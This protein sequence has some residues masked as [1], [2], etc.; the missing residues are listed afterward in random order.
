M[1]TFNLWIAIDEVQVWL[2]IHVALCF[3]RWTWLF[4]Q[5]YQIAFWTWHSWIWCLTSKVSAQRTLPCGSRLTFHCSSQGLVQTPCRSS[6]QTSAVTP[7]ERCELLLNLK[8]QICSLPASICNW[9]TS[10][11][12]W[13]QSERT[14]SCVQ[15]PLCNPVQHCLQLHT[16]LPRV[17]VQPRYV[18]VFASVFAMCL[19]DEE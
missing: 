18:C 1:D 7:T 3:C 8:A 17:P 13:L 11:F 15:R 2:L 12:L 14:W 4:L 19:S 16:R 10:M 9:F 6:P 5:Q